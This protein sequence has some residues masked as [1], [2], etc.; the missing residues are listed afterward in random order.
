MF[1]NFIYLL[2]LLL[3]LNT[4]LFLQRYIEIEIIYLFKIIIIILFFRQTVGEFFLIGL[5]MM[6]GSLSLC[7]G[8]IGLTALNLLWFA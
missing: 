7:F 3:S 5:K 6:G 1:Q 4:L 8:S 2:L